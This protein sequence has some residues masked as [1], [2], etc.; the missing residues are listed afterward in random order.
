M[1]KSELRPVPERRSWGM[2]RKEL[3]VALA[4][5]FGTAS[6][7]MEPEARGE[8]LQGRKS[9]RMLLQE[10]CQEISILRDELVKLRERLEALERFRGMAHYRFPGDIELMGQR[11]PLERRDLWERMDREFLLLVND[12]PQVLLWM[13]R[14]NRYFPII[15]KRIEE[16]GLPRDLKFVAIV[17]SS[18]RPEARSSAGAVGVW[19]FIPSTG[20][21]YSLEINEWIDERQD[22]VKSTDAALAYLQYLKAKFDDWLLALAAYNLGED[23]LRR[24]MERQGVSS[25]Y[26]LVLPQETERYIFRIAAAKVILSDPG[27]YGFDLLPEELY[28]PLDVKTLE[29]KLEKGLDLIALARS[30]GMTYRALKVLNPHIKD[31]WL[32]K[33][34]YRLYVPRDKADEVARALKYQILSASERRERQSPAPAKERST[35]KKGAVVHTVR[36]GETLWDIAK[37]YGVQVRSIQQ[38]NQLSSSDRIAPGQ[39]LFI[40]ASKK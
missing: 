15:E 22:P 40:Y 11:I 8:E 3:V 37:S 4:L 18:L 27:K 39:K 9:V 7:G 29:V 24:E 35:V 14:A 12:V 10:A 5:A 36:Q 38:W 21:L 6:I 17:E 23:R 13:K 28:D 33:G 34:I 2:G 26:E 1:G 30:C 25:F 31:T 16:K 32:P 20:S 19:Q